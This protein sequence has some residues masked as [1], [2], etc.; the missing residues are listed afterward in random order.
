[1]HQ[2]YWL[3]SPLVFLSV[4]CTV[5]IALIVSKK[6]TIAREERKIVGAFMEKITKIPALVEVMRKYISDER[7]FENIIRLYERSVSSKYAVMY[8]VLEENK[9]LHGE[10]AFLLK[11][12]VK[13]PLLHKDGNF[14]SARDR[15][16]FYENPLQ[17]HLGVL[18][19]QIVSYNR[20]RKWKNI[21]LIGFL[22]PFRSLL[23]IE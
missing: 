16:L 1:M 23:E 20:L 7:V 3:V 18:N 4:A 15:I 10:I 14:H 5:F 9:A 11:Y 8:D 21:T 19:G 12:A 13:T 6:R 2:F 17:K 22:F